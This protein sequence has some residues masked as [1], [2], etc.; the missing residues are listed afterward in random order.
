MVKVITFGCKYNLLESEIIKKTSLSDDCVII[1]TCA[2]TGEA[3]RQCRQEIRKNY[4]LGKKV[5]VTGCAAKINEKI[6]ASMPEV[7]QVADK[8]DLLQGKIVEGFENRVRAYLPIQTGCSYRCTFCIVP[9]ARGNGI[10]YEIPFLVDKAKEMVKSGFKEIVLTG[11][12]IASYRYSLPGLMKR[13]LDVDGLCRLRLSSLD[14]ALLDDEFIRLYAERNSKLMPHIHLSVQ[15]GD[16]VVLRKMAR[17]HRRRD[18]I[19]IR[20]SLPDITIGADIIAGF[21]EE[22]E[23]MFMNT[24]KLVDEVFI[25]H[26]HIFPYSE[27]PGT[28]AAAMPQI[29]KHIRRERAKLLREKT[30]GNLDRYLNSCIGGECNVLVESKNKGFNEHYV[31]VK[32]KS[33]A[34]AGSI[35]KVK[36]TGKEDGCLVG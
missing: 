28:P 25:T 4:R 35:E 3:E 30:A 15:S 19:R 6:Y 29:D 32:L 36:I 23:E 17:R 8:K 12:N 7:Y 13:L 16:D 9:Y 10:S 11:I 20:E 18:I 34:R 24:V 26:G 27:R 1:N 31:T 2:V 5:I 22:N 33:A 21:P 14:P